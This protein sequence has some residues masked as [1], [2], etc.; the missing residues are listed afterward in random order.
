MA[1]DISTKKRDAT[2][3]SLAGA[4]PG[5]AA[6][7]VAVSA[8]AGVL[9]RRHALDESLADALGKPG[10]SPLAPRDR[11]FAQLLASTVIRR[12]GVLQAVIASCLEKPLSEKHA[13]VGILLLTGAAQLLF[14]STPPHAAISLAVDH[15]R[16]V[17]GGARLDKL[18]NAVLRRVARDGPA[19]LA[20][21]D[22]V[23][24]N[25]PHWMWKRWHDAYG[26][27]AARQIAAASLDE[28]ALDISVKSEPAS[29]AER[30]GGTLLPTGSIRLDAGG[31]IE[32]LPG[33][34]EG[35]WWVQDL[36]A[37]IPARL[38]GDVAGLR[39]AD[40]CAAPG[41][42]TAGLAAAGA[43][44]TAV[45]ISKSR[46]L[47][48]AE[49]LKRLGLEAQLIAADI[50][51]AAPPEPFDAVLLDAPCTAT[52]TIRRHP[53]IL[54]LK[55]ESDVAALAALQAKMLDRA[56]AM[57][58]PGGLLVY[59]TCSLEPE[60][61]VEQIEQLLVRD[62]SL[63]RVPVSATEFDGDPAWITAAGDLRTLPF[64]AVGANTTI[65]GLDGF[66]AA[67]L[68]KAA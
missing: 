50:C 7:Q 6:R 3:A 68:R 27:H 19:H 13:E 47:R 46:L 14:L 51:A 1:N 22:A 60:E 20:S 62:T 31:R 10:V 59:C 54:R 23:K 58:K 17:P 67:R 16:L 39:V 29:W 11:A 35:A 5:L 55:R 25:I 56:S 12:S 15:C 41:G 32:D 37:A 61:G 4:T 2:G 48:V 43:L 49:N 26:E 21:L 9:L 24:V 42:K 30:L 52:G 65:T 45:D 66:Y 40:L 18:V 33:F 8:A 44:V 57:L 63:S 64:H 38:L 36:G 28:A 34:Q 53:D